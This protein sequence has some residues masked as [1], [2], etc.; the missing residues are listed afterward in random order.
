MGRSDPLKEVANNLRRAPSTTYCEIR[1]NFYR[2][3]EVPKLNS[4]YAVVV[5]GNYE[6]CGASQAA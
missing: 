3:E 1:R 2:D 4:Y 6:D 5:R